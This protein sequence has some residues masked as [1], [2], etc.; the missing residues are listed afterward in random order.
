[1]YQLKGIPV[2]NIATQGQVSGQHIFVSGGPC[3]P[4]VLGLLKSVLA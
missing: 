1:M 2:T 3:L 4:T